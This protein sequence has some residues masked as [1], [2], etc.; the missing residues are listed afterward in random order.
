MIKIK[1]RPRKALPIFL[2]GCAFLSSTA[3]SGVDFTLD[4]PCPTRD[5]F[6]IIDRYPALEN[7]DLATARPRRPY[8]I[9]MDTAAHHIIPFNVL[10]DFYNEVMNR[11]DPVEMYQLGDS[12]IFML[13]EIRV[14]VENENNFSGRDNSRFLEQAIQFSEEIRDGNIPEISTYMRFFE[15]DRRISEGVMSLQTIYSW[16]PV[17]VFIGPTPEYRSDDPGDSFE[18]NAGTIVG[19]EHY[20][21]LNT[22]NNMMK[23]CV[24]RTLTVSFSELIRLLNKVVQHP[25][26]VFQFNND[27]WEVNEYTGKWKIRTQSP[28]PEKIL[29]QDQ[30]TKNINGKYCPGRELNNDLDCGKVMNYVY[31]NIQLRYFTTLF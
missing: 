8:P 19:S 12:F 18:I 14:F 23:T 16:L 3:N 22:L 26:F 30:L 31:K 9:T 27:D 15:L 7:I 4:I 5:C 1:F 25:H 10:R 21:R 6:Q 2:I 13:N 24:H 29:N 11:E 17:N 20:N 28:A